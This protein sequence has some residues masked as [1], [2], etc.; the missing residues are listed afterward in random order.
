MNSYLSRPHTLDLSKENLG[1][2]L[3][4][5]ISLLKRECNR[6]TTEHPQAL[7]NLKLFAND[8]LIKF[9]DDALEEIKDKQSE[10]MWFLNT[11]LKLFNE[12][13]TTVGGGYPKDFIPQIKTTADAY[14]SKNPSFKRSLEEFKKLVDKAALKDDDVQLVYLIWDVENFIANNIEVPLNR[15][16][17]KI[18]HIQNF[19]KWYDSELSPEAYKMPS[20]TPRR[21]HRRTQ[22]VMMGKEVLDETGNRVPMSEFKKKMK[23]YSLS[24]TPQENINETQQ[25]RRL[26]D[27]PVKSVFDDVEVASIP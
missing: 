14:A 3:P 5:F 8:L 2:D 7:I 12:M 20:E 18:K 24:P 25:P 6:A 21:G 10:R 22:D 4:A 11:T 9:F 27:P 17:S 13:L 19:I 26:S 1:K 15:L 16:E 23:H